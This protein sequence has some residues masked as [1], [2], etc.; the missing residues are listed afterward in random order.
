MIQNFP[1]EILYHI[2]RYACVDQGTTARTLS[3]T[4]KY[5]SSVSSRFL[6]NTLYLASA[7]HLQRALRRLSSLPAHLRPVCHLFIADS[8]GQTVGKSIPDSVRSRILPIAT[9]RER[10]KS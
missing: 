7:D 6:F 4:S 10:A 8:N 3:L 2:F 9:V 5:V 1:P